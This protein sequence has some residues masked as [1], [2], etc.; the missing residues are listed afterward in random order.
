MPWLTGWEIPPEF[1]DRYIPV[2]IRIRP[3]SDASNE[4]KPN[5]LD[6]FSWDVNFKVAFSKYSRL[7]A[8][9]AARRPW[10]MPDLKT[11]FNRIR[12]W[13]HLKLIE[14]KVVI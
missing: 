14:W 4:R 12:Y 3:F 1:R 7:A 9:N 6:S 10:Y 8:L 11:R 5:L 2:G 13:L